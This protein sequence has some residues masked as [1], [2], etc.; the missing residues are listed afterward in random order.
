MDF[1]H[2]TEA[3]RRNN[4]QVRVFHTEE[5][6]AR[7]LD[8]S[9]DG[10]SVGFGDSNTLQQIDLYNLLVKYSTVH[11]PNQT[12]S[13]DEFKEVAVSCLTAEVF[14]SSVKAMLRMV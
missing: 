7:Y 8:Q 3:L 14:L 9:I 1:A 11:D 13:D 4:Y 2:L 10:C 5:V 12:A 6:A